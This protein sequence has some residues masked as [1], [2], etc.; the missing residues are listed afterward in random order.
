MMYQVM[1]AASKVCLKA[2]LML[3]RYLLVYENARHN[4]APN[5]PPVDAPNSRRVLAL[6]RI[7][8]GRAACQ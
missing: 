5:P 3:T 6:R 7:R 4:V 2:R 1:R 8:L